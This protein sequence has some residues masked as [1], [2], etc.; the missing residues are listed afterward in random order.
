MTFV[1]L[2]L[3]KPTSRPARLELGGRMLA[4]PVCASSQDD[5]HV[6]IVSGGPC[7]HVP[8]EVHRLHTN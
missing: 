5:E 3:H 1:E 7:Q 4:S 6:L 2:D 8:V